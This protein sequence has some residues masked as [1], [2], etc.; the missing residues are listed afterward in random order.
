VGVNQ[1]IRLASGRTVG[2]A[3]HGRPDGIAVIWCHGGPGSRLEPGY[4]APAAVDAGL[5]IV[6]IDRPGYGL[7]TPE[8]GRTIGG[9]VPEALAVVDHLG[10]DRFVTVGISTGGAYALAVAALAP[11]RVLG[12][13]PCCAMTDMRYQPARATV[14]RPH[15]H[16]VWD[17]PDRESAMAAAIESH[18]IDGSKIVESAEGPPLAPSDLAMLVDHAFG[19]HWTAALPAMF[20]Q[21]LEGYTDDRLA[22]GGGWTSFDVTDI[23]CP[24]IVLHGGADV[25]ADPIHARH[26]AAIVP[27]AELR[28][29]DAL[30]HFS[31]QDQLVSTILDALSRRSDGA[32]RRSLRGTPGAEP[33][34]SPTRRAQE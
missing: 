9:W 20:A 26:T 2:F 12:V 10:I 28:I 32:G 33:G 34:P 31:I 3:D 4:V 13:V 24:V 22:D 5:R 8:P 11:G 29:F 21:G 6:G 17:A 7:S 25:V 23:A 16:A 27:G 15:A 19:R 30:G 14:S 18:G 1:T